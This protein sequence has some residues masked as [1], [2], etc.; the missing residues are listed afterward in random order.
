M[1]QPSTYTAFAASKR[2]ATGEIRHTLQRCK[3]Q[4]DS[5]DSARIL[6]F[7]DR[8][9]K[10]IDFDFRGS[11]EDIVA[12][13]HSHPHFSV[14]PAPKAGPG[15]PKLGVVSREVTLLPRHWEYLE[16]QPQGISAALRRLVDEARLKSPQQGRSRQAME[17]AD[18]FMWA[19]AGDF[20]HCE[21]A[22][23]A[24]YAQDDK[25]LEKSIRAWPK[26][27][28]HHLHRLLSPDT[29]ETAS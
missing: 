1:T 17:A 25:R 21:E 28:K 23:R 6:V 22:S 9:G 3:A 19:V 29:G 24:L 13:L 26:D 8:T 2:I 7:E 5:G 15:R 4:L 10:Q 18:K 12:R 11:L 20:P 14:P 16:Q 27:I